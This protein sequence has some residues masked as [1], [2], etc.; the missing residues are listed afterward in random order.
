MIST[1]KHYMCVTVALALL[2]GGLQRAEAGSGYFQNFDSGSSDSVVPS[3]S[4]WDDPT[5][6]HG[7]YTGAITKNSNSAYG[8]IFV[9]GI[10]SDVSG[11]G[12]FLFEGTGGPGT[13]GT[14][15]FQ[16]PTFSVFQN[17][18]YTVSFYLTNQNLTNVASLQPEIDSQSL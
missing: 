3:S 13:V 1:V 9:T 18:N 6:A 7:D 11:A 17:T 10:D 4:Y 5:G 14:V 12:Y 16:S 8:G 15:M 2:A